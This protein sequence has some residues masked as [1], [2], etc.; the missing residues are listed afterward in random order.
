[1]IARAT[2]ISA[3]LKPLRLR[4]LFGEELVTRAFVICSSA[5]S[6]KDDVTSYKLL[7]DRYGRISAPAVI[8]TVT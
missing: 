6:V 1:M 7:G 8:V 3:R 4:K 2:R 5:V